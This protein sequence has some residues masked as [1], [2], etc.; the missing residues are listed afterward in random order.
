MRMWGYVDNDSPGG[1]PEEMHLNDEVRAWR[2]YSMLEATGWRFLP[3]QL[4]AEDMQILDDV[5]ALRNLRAAIESL[6]EEQKHSH[7]RQHD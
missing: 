2:I 4:L 6:L 1:V 3:S 7:D 5:L